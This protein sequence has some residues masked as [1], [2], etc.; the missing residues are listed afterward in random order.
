VIDNL[1]G[2]GLLGDPLSMLTDG[3]LTD[4]LVVERKKRSL[5]GGYRAPIRDTSR[6]DEHA[7]AYDLGQALMNDQLAQV[8]ASEIG[9]ELEEDS[10]K[11]LAAQFGSAII[12]G[13]SG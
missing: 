8:L 4:S 10:T 5:G 11:R 6:I 2:F 12:K 1:L 7:F 3:L 9:A 13:N